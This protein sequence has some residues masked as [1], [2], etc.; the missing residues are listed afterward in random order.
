MMRRARLLCGL[1]IVGA[2]F[3]TACAKSPQAKAEEA[4]KVAASWEAT[5]RLLDEQQARGALPGAFVQQVRRAA[6]DAREEAAAQRRAGG[7]R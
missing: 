3:V 4:A 7:A 2:A 1:T 6:A 5:V